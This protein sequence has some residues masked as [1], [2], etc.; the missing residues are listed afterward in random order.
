[1]SSQSDTLLD[2]WMN[3]DRDASNG[4]SDVSAQRGREAYHGGTES[5][6]ARIYYLLEGLGVINL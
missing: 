1:M 3:G 2:P 5:E 6:N 4:M